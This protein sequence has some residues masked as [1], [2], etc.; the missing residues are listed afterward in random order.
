MKNFQFCQSDYVMITK[1]M[2]KVIYCEM[3]T[4]IKKASERALLFVKFQFDPDH[5][6][7]ARLFLLYKSSLF[8]WATDFMEG[9]FM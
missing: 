6:N 8:R 7:K 3:F 4:Q 5:S 1:Q 9:P 2:A